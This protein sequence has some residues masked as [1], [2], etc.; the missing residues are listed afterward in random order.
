MGKEGIA[1]IGRCVIGHSLNAKKTSH[2]RL[3]QEGEGG[4][5]RACLPSA[6]KFQA[7]HIPE[8]SASVVES[9]RMKLRIPASARKSSLIRGYLD[10]LVVAFDTTP[11]DMLAAS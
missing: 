4:T 3:F 8:A 1:V 10:A 2:M 6:N 7:T 9:V 5:N 11:F